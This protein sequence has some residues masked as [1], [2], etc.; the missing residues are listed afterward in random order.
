MKLLIGGDLYGELVGAYPEGGIIGETN[1][2]PPI[3]L[4]R[5]RR[6]RSIPEV[7]HEMAWPSSG[8]VK[9][10]CDEVAYFPLT[11]LLGKFEFSLKGKGLHCRLWRGNE[12]YNE[13]NIYFHLPHI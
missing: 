5:V 10:A 13:I 9:R 2:T 11:L 7:F 3:V 6:V 4:R 12:N 8:R 1:N